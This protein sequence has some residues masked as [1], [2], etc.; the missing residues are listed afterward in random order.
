MLSGD[1]A[2]V[3][4]NSGAKLVGRG[5]EGM[6]RGRLSEVVQKEREYWERRNRMGHC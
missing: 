5:K 4:G 2:R 6:N 1:V 3:R